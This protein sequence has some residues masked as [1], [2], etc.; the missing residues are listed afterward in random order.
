ME[1]FVMLVFLLIGC[2]KSEDL[3]GRWICSDEGVSTTL[4]LFSDGTGTFIQG[5]DS[6]SI[7]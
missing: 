7:S 5:E 1:A 4:E 2:G 6:Y 3:T